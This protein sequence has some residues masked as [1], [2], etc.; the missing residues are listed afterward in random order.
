MSTDSKSNPDPKEQP[1]R[2]DAGGKIATQ[3]VTDELAKA[4]KAMNRAKWT[5]IILLAVVGGY[6]GFITYYFTG[7]MEPK[8][9]AAVATSMLSERVDMHANEIA[10]KIRQDVPAMVRDIPDKIIEGLPAWRNE[11]EVKVEEA[12]V[13]NLARHSEEFGKHL[14]DFLALHQAEVKEL[15]DH[16]SDREKLKVFMTSLEQDVLSY[17]DA[18]AEDG[19]TIKQKLDVSLEAIQNIEKHMNRLANGNDLNAQELKTRRAIAL[20]S[21]KVQSERA[22]KGPQSE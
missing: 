4:R 7:F 9:V 5:A 20:I 21:R 11:L 6:M 19:E 13:D 8:N 15:L 10:D 22:A 17:L 2:V 14:D 12:L 18:E 1:M 16:T 3:F